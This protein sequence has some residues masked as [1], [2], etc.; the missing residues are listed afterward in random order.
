MCSAC[1]EDGKE[2][3]SVGYC[4]Q[5]SDNLCQDCMNAHSRTRITKNH[6]ITDPQV[7]T[8]LI[9]NDNNNSINSQDNVDEAASEIP[10][11]AEQGNNNRIDDISIEDSEDILEEHIPEIP[12][13]HTP[14]K[15]EEH[16]PEILEEHTPDKPEEHTPEILEEHTPDK[17]EEHT[18]EKPEEHTPDKPEEHTPDKPEEHSAEK[19]EEHSAEKPEEHTTEKPKEH[20]PEKPKEKCK[21]VK[22]SFCDQLVHPNYLKRHEKTQKCIKERKKNGRH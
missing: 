22:C 18:P 20:T 14:D 2:A 11:E 17:H 3:F 1:I 7:P 15:P 10:Q 5:C 13:E 6:I 12:E 21:K 16:T 4:G 9:M 8:D 19:P